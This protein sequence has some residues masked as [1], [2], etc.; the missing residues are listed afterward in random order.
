M[1]NIYESDK[2]VF[3]APVSEAAPQSAPST[4][5]EADN[6]SEFIR[7]TTLDLPLPKKESK[8]A[9][10][11]SSTTIVRQLVLYSILFLLSRLFLI[12]VRSDH[13][14]QPALIPTHLFH[15][16]PFSSTSRIWSRK[17]RLTTSIHLTIHS[18]PYHTCYSVLIHSL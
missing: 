5:K 3:P 18:P 14:L 12:M 2:E 15:F 11:V 7:P 6:A 1:T 16:I 4:S 9:Q 10:Q 17:L 8:R 13:R